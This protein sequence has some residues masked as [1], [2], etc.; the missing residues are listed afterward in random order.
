MVHRIHYTGQS[1][2][3]GDAVAE[4][5]VSYAAALAHA[6]RTDMVQIP[7]VGSGD[8]RRS[9]TLLI[10]QALPIATEDL[11]PHADELEDER[12]VAVL[13]ARIRE[14]IRPRPI[15]PDLDGGEGLFD[16]ETL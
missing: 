3:T 13:A 9:L 12:L 14:V 7:T 10:G 16:A 11:G 4:A 1:F 5:V 2:T 8:Q 15:R 6:G